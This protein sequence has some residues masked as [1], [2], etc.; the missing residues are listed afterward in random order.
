MTF[1]AIVDNAAINIGRQ[2]YLFKIPISII[3]GKYPAI[4]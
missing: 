4:G 1:K 2:I 3:L